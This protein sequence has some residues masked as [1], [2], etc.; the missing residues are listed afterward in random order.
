M[1]IASTHMNMRLHS[2]LGAWAPEKPSVFS[3][4][5]SYSVRSRATMVLL[6]K[7]YHGTV[8]KFG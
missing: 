6:E 7:P 4:P 3:P 5:S 1:Q 8:K 2:Q